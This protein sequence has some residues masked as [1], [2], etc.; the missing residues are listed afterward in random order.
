[1]PPP[2]HGGWYACPAGIRRLVDVGIS[3]S[4][5]RALRPERPKDGGGVRV[6]QTTPNSLSKL[7]APLFSAEIHSRERSPM[8]KED[9]TWPS[10]FIICAISSAPSL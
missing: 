1:M 9:K 5:A 6:R 2:P 7:P 4:S 10:N 3:G 8:W